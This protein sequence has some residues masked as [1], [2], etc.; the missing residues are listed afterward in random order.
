MYG[1]AYCRLDYD[2]MMEVDLDTL[3]RLLKAEIDRELHQYD[4][5]MKK[6]AWQTAYLMN[7]TGNYKKP[8]KPEK[9]YQSILEQP[10]DTEEKEEKKKSIE[11]ER[12]YLKKAFGL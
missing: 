1:L 5:D 11:A 10:K 4:I 6:L 12:E 8:V 9:L 3:S 7:A 2:Y